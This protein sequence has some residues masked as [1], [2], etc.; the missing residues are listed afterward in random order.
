MHKLVPVCLTVSYLVLAFASASPAAEVDNLAIGQDKE[1]LVQMLCSAPEIDSAGNDVAALVRM[2]ENSALCGKKEETAT[3]IDF[4]LKD[5]E[6]GETHKSLLE[7]SKSIGEDEGIDLE[8][9]DS[10]FKSENTDVPV[11][12]SVCFLLSGLIGLSSMGRMRSEA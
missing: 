11:P 2:S 10:R 6:T 8:K 12:A 4:E 3:L 9:S 5:S 1:L 7:E